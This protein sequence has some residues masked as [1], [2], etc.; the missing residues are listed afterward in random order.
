M[1]RMI[2]YELAK[3]RVQKKNFVMI[4]CHLC[5]LALCYL[6]FRSA[7]GK[8]FQRFDRTMNFHLE[9][10]N[11]YLDGLF[12]A[13]VAL[14]PTF[15]VLM[16]ILVATLAGDTV[17]GEMQD[18]SLKL[19]VSRARSR[20]AILLSK[21]F[22]V[23][24]VTLLFCIWFAAVNLLIGVAILG[25]SP[26]QLVMLTDRMFGTDVVVMG[27]GGALLRYF[28]S[29]VYF[30]FSL[31]ALAAIT[32]FF[33]TV[34]NRMSAA[35]VTVISLYFVS[36]VIAALPFSDAIRPWLLSEVMNNAFLLWLSPLPLFKL[37][38]NCATLLLYM[39]GFLLAA[40]L[41]FNWK[42]LK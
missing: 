16:P 33:S 5:F 26:T 14:V 24:I 32:L 1:F 37:L 19:Y 21:F 27:C 8:F 23:Y 4:A 11:D 18:G 22:A 35:T 9:N 7:Q 41:M 31:T 39:A 15:I 25:V 17:A 28:A 36:Y 6:A 13:R 29:M 34:F 40:V 12:F 2:G 3:L 30:S 20:S 38:L 10:L 42:D